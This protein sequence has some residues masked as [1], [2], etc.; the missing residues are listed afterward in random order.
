SGAS[1]Q[2]D[3]LS[4]FLTYIP[5]IQFSPVYAAIEN[6]HFEDAGLH[7]NIQHGD[8]PDGV[9]LIAVGNVDFGI[10]SGEQIIQARANE[11]D[12]VFVYEWFQKYPVGIVVPDDGDIQTVKDLAGRHVGIPGRFGA[13]Y[14]GL[15][16]LLSGNDMRE[17]DIQ[18]EAIGY[19]APEVFCLG[20]VEAA[21]I[22]TNNEPLQIQQQADAGECGDVTGVKVFPVS[23]AADMVSNGIV[24]S[25]AM[26]QDNPE[27]VRAVVQA[28]DAGLQDVINNPAQAYLLSASYVENLPLD[29]DFRTAL[30]QEAESQSEFLATNSDRA[31]IAESRQALLDR[32][33]ESFE[34]ESLL[35]FEVLLASIDLWDADQLGYTDPASWETTQQVLLTMG[36]VP[37]EIDLSAAYSNAFLPEAISANAD[38][39]DVQAVE[40]ADNS[41]TFHVT[42]V[43]PDTGWEDYANGWDVVLPDGSV[44]KPDPESPF[45]RLLLHPHETEQPFT[46]SQSDIV[47]PS[48]VDTVTVRAHDLVDGYGGHEVVVD[49]TSDSGDGFSVERLS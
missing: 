13:S 49:L 37:E 17:E 10:V 4:F 1:A 5:N 20:A 22:Y 11:R 21:V 45:T 29:D 34:G 8:E 39:V 41:W 47:I 12:V 26:I 35:Q 44:V 46:R 7:V 9:D 43:H 2:S 27:R 32:L 23:D 28:F 36:F 6:G 38:V 16:A 25:N 14:S 33:S 24:T 30:E 3:E 18:L 48:D 40:V 42:V 19:N 31:A 15:I